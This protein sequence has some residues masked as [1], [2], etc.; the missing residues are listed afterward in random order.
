M[1]TDLSVLR[2]RIQSPKLADRERRRY[3][4]VMMT[5]EGVESRKIA[6]T[7][8][9]SLNTVYLWKKRYHL[10]GLEAISTP[11]HSP[12]PKRID[13]A[14]TAKKIHKLLKQK[15]PQ[16]R[17]WTIRDLAAKLELSSQTVW[18][19]TKELNVD[20]KA[21][22]Q[23]SRSDQNT[24]TNK[25][26]KVL[27]QKAGTPLTLDTI[28]Q[29]TNVSKATVSLALRDDPRITTDVK[30]K[31]QAMAAQFGY[32]RNAGL[33]VLSDLRWRN[34]P[35]YPTLAVITN[36][37]EAQE[38]LRASFKENAQKKGYKLE[39]FNLKKYSNFKR[40]SDVLYARGIQGVIL[41]N[42]NNPQALKRDF[43]WKRFAAV[44]C[45]QKAPFPHKVGPDRHVAA[46]FTWQ[47]V[48]RAGYE[49]IGLVAPKK[50]E[51]HQVAPIAVAL[52]QQ[53]VYLPKERQVPLFIKEPQM[54][55][56]AFR[57]W[58]KKHRPDAIIATDYRYYEQIVNL[59]Y[60]IPRDVAFALTRYSPEITESIAGTDYNLKAIG[61]HTIQ[62]LD[63]LLRSFNFGFPETPLQLFTPVSWHEGDS[64]P[65]RKKINH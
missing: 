52:T 37:F 20:L 9:V 8:G 11:N 42:V 28:A 5:L 49:R 15:P 43:D 18:R 45:F 65:N 38:P 33:S 26:K 47:T 30:K 22:P 34:H 12:G 51:Q 41:V 40:L 56:K 29:A 16:G 36:T 58:M 48:R 46:N 44:C 27:K 61:T 19:M 32:Q 4:I 39:S 1:K 63:S 54:H 31:V 3:Q 55:P 24:K 7:L 60:S 25:D 35:T 50:N 14:K 57:A 17:R 64:L 13:R 23:Y 21:T 62:L 6:E 2:K 10:S 53:F 59:G